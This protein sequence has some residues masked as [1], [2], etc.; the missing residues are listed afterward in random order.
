MTQPKFAPILEQ[1]EVREVQKI[2][3]PPPWTP[4]RPGEHRPT[5][6]VEHRD[7]LGVPGPDQGYALELAKR[8]EDRIVLQAGERR[9]DVLAGAVAIA[10]RRAAIFGRAPVGADIAFALRLFGY[11]GGEDRSL[12]SS[13][14][15]EFRRELFTGADHDYWRRRAIADTVPETTLRLRPEELDDRLE[16]DP[17]SWRDLLGT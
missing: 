12:A 2:G 9:E 13:D 7:G 5:P 1:D 14:L 17:G 6:R 4:H 11:L 3:V 10:L 16:R 15:W 8:F